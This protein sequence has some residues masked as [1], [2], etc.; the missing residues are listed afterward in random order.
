MP[1]Q[2]AR[3]LIV[4]DHTSYI[5]I[6][7][8]DS[9]NRIMVIQN[10]VMDIHNYIIYSCL[11]F[12]IQRTSRCP[13]FSAVLSISYRFYFVIPSST[14]LNG[15]ILVSPC[16]S[17]RLSVCG[18]N[19]ARCVS[20]TVLA[21]L[22]SYLHILS[23]YQQ[24]SEGVLCIEFREKF[25]NLNF[26]NSFEFATLTLPCVRVIWKVKSWFMASSEWLLQQLLFFRDDTSIWF[27]RSTYSI[28]QNPGTPS[29]LGATSSC[30]GLPRLALSG[31]LVIFNIR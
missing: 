26:G 5:R 24:L 7:T 3:S 20:S 14:K 11:A 23:A 25:Q 8:M 9:H 28:F 31:C 6:T 22:I 1:C 21:S 19:R 13:E 18:Q 16:S 17:V 15:S 12:R 30:L 4:D 2:T 27:N 29:C 10:S